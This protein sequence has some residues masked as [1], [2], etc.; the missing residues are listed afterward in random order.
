[1]EAFAKDDRIVYPKKEGGRLQLKSYLHEHEEWAPTSVFYKDRRAAS[2]SL[3]ALMGANVFDYP[4]DTEVLGRLFHAI[5]DEGDLIVDFFAGSGSTGHAVWQQNT[6]DGK[7][8]HWILVQAPEKPDPSEESGKNALNAGYETIFDITAERLR[9]AAK[10]IQ[11][12]T[13]NASALG[14]RVFRTCPTNLIIEKPIMATP[15]LTGQTYLLQILDQASSAPVVNGAKPIDVAWEVALKATRTRLDARVVTHNIDGV[16]VYEFIPS[17]MNSP[18]GRLLVSL[19]EFSLTTSDKLS[20]TDDDT[21]ILR[22]DRV[23]DSVTLTLAS[24]LQS[25]L[26]LLERVPRE[27]SL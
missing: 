16:V 8:R 23:E 14:F 17:D 22:S 20:V 2:K 9:R 10:S 13:S 1:M 25:K 4:K 24:R 6:K 15:E 27:V 7:T 5:T 18:V 3:D 11:E 21:L 12:G 26:I 19:D